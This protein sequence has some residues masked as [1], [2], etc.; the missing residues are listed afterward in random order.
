MRSRAFAAEAVREATRRSSLLA[1]AALL[2]AAAAAIH[3][4]ADSVEPASLYAAVLVVVPVALVPLAARA[5]TRDHESSFASVAE[6]SV[7][8][9]GARFAGRAMALAALAGLLVAL[10][11]PA[12]LALAAPLARGSGADPIPFAAAGFALAL[13]SCAAGLLVGHAF[14]RRPSV[15]LTVAFLVAGA[16]IGLATRGRELAALVSGAA[17]REALLALVAADPLAR[18]LAAPASARDLAI[19]AVMA[20]ALAA[21]AFVVAA[22]L[23][24]ALEIARPRAAARPV[25]A[26]AGLALVFSV[27]AAAA[28]V[29]AEPRAL[30][31][32]SSVIDLGDLRVSADLGTGGA[33]STNR[34]PLASSRDLVLTAFVE[35]PPGAVVRVG[36]LALASESFRLAPG[37]P[38]PDALDL[39]SSGFAAFGVPLDAVA[40]PPSRFGSYTEAVHVSLLLDDVPVA[41]TSALTIVAEPAPARA[42]ALA[43][44]APAALLA[45]LAFAAEWRLNRW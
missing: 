30:S 12:T 23:C 14:A 34:V 17:A 9:R 32:F 15:A 3:S 11:T 21:A 37:A 18:A 40:N 8:A 5:A 4:L 35:G 2:V 31:A 1:I 29:E 10:A 25:A 43:A 6:A 16:W 36:A 45:V 38:P 41:L 33:S 20:L 7:G 26:L 42:A 27:A 44:L 22:R 24:G 39:G 28:D 19:L 13:A